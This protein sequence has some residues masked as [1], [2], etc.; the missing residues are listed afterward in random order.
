M[1]FHD[2]ANEKAVCFKIVKGCLKMSS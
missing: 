2:G 1:S